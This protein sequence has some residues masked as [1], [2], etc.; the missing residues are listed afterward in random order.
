METLPVDVVGHILSFVHYIGSYKPTLPQLRCVSR[1]F[2]A[3][4]ISFRPLWVEYLGSSG[5]MMIGPNSVHKGVDSWGRSLTSNCKISA[6]TKR[7]HIFT[8]YKFDTLVLKYSAADAYKAHE[9][10]MTILSKKYRKRID[11]LIGAN[12]RAQKRLL[13]KYDAKKRQL[14]DEAEML[15]KRYKRHAE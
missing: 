5:P 15:Q 10:A 12:K 1:S 2:N 4:I 6:K 3:A 11:A 14:D 9:K 8:H 7:C 13:D